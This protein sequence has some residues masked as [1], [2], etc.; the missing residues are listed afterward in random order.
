[1]MDELT[2]ASEAED[3]APTDRVTGE[4]DM[5]KPAHVGMLGADVAA[6]IRGEFESTM[7]KLYQQASGGAQGA[8]AGAGAAA[9]GGGGDEDI[10]DADF[11]VK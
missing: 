8:Q 6:A 1:M 9:G 11:E 7:Q 4:I 10:K 3:D 2:Q 5:T